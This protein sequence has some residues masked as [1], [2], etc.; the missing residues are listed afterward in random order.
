[1]KILSTEIYSLSFHVLPFG[2]TDH[3]EIYT[4]LVVKSWDLTDIAVGPFCSRFHAYKKR[5][6]V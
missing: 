1:M 3:E 2:K 5:V 6:I 4:I